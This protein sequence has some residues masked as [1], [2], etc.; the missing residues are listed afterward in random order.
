M[1]DLDVVVIGAGFGGLAATLTL[2]EA[3]AKVA[4]CETLSYPG[5]CASTFTRDGYQFES[6]ATLLSG[7]A[8]EQLFGRWI[9]NYQMPLQLSWM[10]PLLSL[11]TPDVTIDI[12]R[13]REDLVEQLC[14]LPHAPVE[15]LQRFF[16]AQRRVASTMWALFDNPT[17]LPPV[18][19]RQIPGHLG[20]LHTYAALVPYV[21]RSLDDILHRFSLHDFRPLRSYLDAL[22]Q[23]TL[24]CSAAVAEAPLAFA[25]MDYYYRG[26]AHIEGGI[27]KFAQAISDAAHKMG[28]AI[29]MS[30]RVKSVVRHP[31]DTWTVTT[32]RGALRARHVIANLHP[33]VL[34]KLVGETYQE[35]ARVAKLRQGLDKG[36]S[37]AMLYLIAKVPEQDCDDAAHHIELV[38]NANAPMINGNHIFISISSAAEARAPVGHR[39]LTISTHLPLSTLQ[40]PATDI[41]AY[42]DAVQRQMRAT[43]ATGAPHWAK[44]VVHE[45]TGSART[46]ERF[47][48]RPGGAVGGAPR[49]AGLHNYRNMSALQAAPHLWLV[50]DSVFPGQS[51]LA[52][53]IGGLRTAHHVM[54]KLR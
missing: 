52:A 16:A 40:D 17:Q 49:V 34:P 45:L 35:T 4:L 37:A 20:R 25:A 2:A 33:G 32:R 24:Q 50:G 19:L 10:D 29:H 18:T 51:A 42:T 6:G 22:C 5:G 27:G 15:D 1:S 21:G 9:A 54:S 8:A 39:A 41:A 13:R 14:A 28:A 7:L 46:F 23:I 36:Y 30:S 38:A 53:A 47:V 48:G 3:G 12:S 31:D 11:R 44:G 26:S 43:F